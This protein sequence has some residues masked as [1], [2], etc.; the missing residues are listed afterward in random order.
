MNRCI[1]SKCFEAAKF[2]NEQG[3]KQLVQ[4][5]KTAALKTKY[6][7]TQKMSL[8]TVFTSLFDRKQQLLQTLLQA[9]S[10]VQ[11]LQRGNL[12]TQQF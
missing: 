2:R 12:Y 1:R 8:F 7:V 3:G 9:I 10:E 5:Q 4:T 11:A 6:S